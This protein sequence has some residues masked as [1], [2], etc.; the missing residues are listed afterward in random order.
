LI[1]NN[2]KIKGI[3]MMDTGFSRRKF[4]QSVAGAA[5]LSALG[6]KAQGAAASVEP[7]RVAV[8]GCGIRGVS[9]HIA[10]ACE[11]RLV[12]IVDPDRAAIDS[13]LKKVRNVDPQVDLSKIKNYSDYRRMFDEMGKEL[14]AVIIA[15]P[16]HQHALPALLAIRRGIHVYVE[17]PMTLTIAESRQLVA[18]ARQY[19]VVTQMG[20]QGHIGEGCRRLCEY[21]WAGAIGQV[22]DVYCWSNRANG[23]V[24]GRPPS[25]PVPQGLNWEQWIGPAPYR[26]YHAGL[27]PHDWHDW[28]DFGN[29][30]LGNMGCHI[31]DPAYWALKLGHPS[32]IELEDIFGGNAECYPVSTRIRWEFPARDGMEPVNLHW[33]DGLA[34]GQPYND[35]TVN[36]KSDCVN[37]AYQNRPPLVAQIEKQY[38]RNLGSNGTL[39]VGDKGMMITDAYGDGVRIVPEEAHRAFKKPAATLPRVKGTHQRDFFRACRGGEPACANFD[40]S[41]PLNELVLLGC[42]AIRAGKGK[43]IE[44]DGA[45]MDCANLPELNKF[46]KIESRSGWSC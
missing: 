21:I 41:G 2:P 5:T 24:T 33:Y 18:E 8:L 29:G 40:Y 4:V 16:N 17:K 31:L 44:W 10:A 22:R 39:Y 43:R 20:Q 13:A 9:A 34:S 35:K 30:S 46:L 11:E 26:D 1:W 23:S 12:A 27:H 38:D 6:L 14:D 7:L 37:Q 42:L 36:F 28:F 3:E 15:T 32:A 45:A 25:E 19:G